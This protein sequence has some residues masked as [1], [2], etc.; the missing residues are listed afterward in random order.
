MG[1][2]KRDDAMHARDVALLCTGYDTGARRSELVALDVGDVEWASDGSG[3][4]AIRRSKT[5]QGGEGAVLYIG[6]DTARAITR[7]LNTR[8]APLPHDAPLFVSVHH[9]RL[10]GGDVARILK[11]RA[12]AAGFDAD[13]FSGHSP[14]IGLTHD[15]VAA[16][17]ELGAIMAQGRWRSPA[18][19]CR[20]TK[21]LNAGRSASAQ[22]A[23]MQKRT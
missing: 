15:M 5:D 4:V 14:R 22:L 11:R 12:A 9:R 17:M 6:P 19:V 20:Y 8:P 2:G 10:D 13:L 3:R 1:P 21:R 23:A 16:N 18:M 7:W